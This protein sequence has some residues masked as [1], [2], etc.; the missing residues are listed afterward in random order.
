MNADA[1]AIVFVLM[2]PFFAALSAALWTDVCQKA[3]ARDSRPSRARAR[4]WGGE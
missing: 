1:Q 2:L 4:I 3:D